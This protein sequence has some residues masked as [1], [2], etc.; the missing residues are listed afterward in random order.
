MKAI[1]KVR[2]DYTIYLRIEEEGMI[3]FEALC[4]TIDGA[5]RVAKSVIDSFQK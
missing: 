2:S 1:Y 4:K 5:Y 3:V